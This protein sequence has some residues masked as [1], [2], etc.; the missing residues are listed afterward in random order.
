M[1]HDGSSGVRHEREA[2][3][4]RERLIDELATGLE[5]AR[6]LPRALW[7]GVAWLAFAW[8]TATGLTLATGPL[9]PGVLA[10]IVRSAHF[11]LE[12]LAGLATGLAALIAAGALA[13]VREASWRVIGA[14][15]AALA[16]WA[17]L[18]ALRLAE[19]AS[20]DPLLGKRSTCIVEIFVY[21]LPPLALGLALARRMASLERRWCGALLALAAG[22]IP[23]LWMH[24]A[25]AGEPIHVL[26]AHLAPLVAL[27]ALGAL[28]G[29]LALRR[30]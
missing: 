25:C 3:V 5:P 2:G 26:R 17:A 16:L 20:E 29:G 1:T 14:P 24:V 28:A 7:L 12:L 9:R 6:R 10:E 15:L 13:R 19:P 11:D 8:L 4:R 23:A 27:A 22:A 30:L 21:A 18:V